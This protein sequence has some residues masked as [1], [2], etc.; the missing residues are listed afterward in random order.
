MPRQYIDLVA[1]MGGNTFQE[2][3]KS[4]PRKIRETLFGRMGIKAKKKK[5][6]IR[7][8]GRLEDRAEKLHLRLK[9][10][11]TDQENELCGELLRNWLF[12]K[13]PLL[14]AT[15][16]HLGIENDNGLIE[17]DPEFF[18]ALEE[19]KVVDLVSHLRAKEFSNEEI[20][21]YLTFVETP[22]LEKAL[23]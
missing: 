10:G 16:D 12:T 23:G 2:I 19:D 6:G 14:K 5:V 21:V 1:E 18:K 11:T 22:F 17:E 7:V 9:D 4:S 13:R 3:I 8:H 15:L 20:K